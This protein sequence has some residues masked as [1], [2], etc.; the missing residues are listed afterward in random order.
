MSSAKWRPFWVGLN[1]LTSD[2]AS[3][4]SND[5]NFIETLLDIT[6]YMA[7][8]NYLF[9]NNFTSPRV[10]AVTVKYHKYMGSK[11]KDRIWNV[12]QNI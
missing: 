9:E 7:F 5:G 4:L 2:E 6:Q 1:V 10:Q 8:E 11:T 3:W 12:V